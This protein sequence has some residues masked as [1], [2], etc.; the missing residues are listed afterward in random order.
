MSKPLGLVSL[1]LVTSALAAPHVAFAQVAPAKPDP[2]AT[3][4]PEAAADQTTPPADDAP[5]EEVPEVSVPGGDEIIVTGRVDR[6]IV[7]AAPQVVS[8]L[9]SADIAR[10]G[11]GDIAGALSR[12]TGLSVVGNGFVYVRGLGDRYSLALLNGSPLSSPE[13]LKRSIPLDLFPTSVIASS[14]VQKSYSANFPGEFG[15]GVINLT[16]KAIPK[17]SFLSFGGSISG[18]SETTGQLGYTY[19]GAPSDGTGFDDGSRNQP[20]ALAAFFASRNRISL[21]NVDT[22]AIGRQLISARNVVIQRNKNLPPNGSASISGG[23][24]WDIGDN[25]LG[26]IATLGYS[27]KWRTRDTTQQTASTV[28]LSQREL[29]FQRVITDNRVVVNGLL[30]L[31]FEFGENKLRWTNLYIRD[32][33]KQARLGVGTRESTSPTAT[34]QQQ[35]T[36]FF[37]RQLID[38]HIVAELKPIRGVSV[39]IR[40]GYAN[41]QREAPNEFSFEYFRSNNAADPFGAFFIN[42]LNGNQGRAAVS[43]SD[44]NEDLWSAGVDLSYKLTPGITATIG[45]AFT[46]TKR[47]TER[48]DFQFRAGSGLPTGVALLRPDLLLQPA[49]FDPRTGFGLTLIDTNEANPVFQANLRTNAGYGQVQAEISPTI[50]INAGVRYEKAQ[51]TVRPVQVFNIPF[52][53]LAGTAIRRDYFLPAATLTF[54]L[55]PQMQLRFNG[56]KTIARP[57]FRELIFQPYFD[58]DSNRQFRGNPNLTDSQLTNAE[59]RYEWY[60]AREQRVSVAAFYKRINRPIET[61]SSFSDNNV[62]SSFANAPL[63]NLYGAEVETQKYFNLDAIGKSPFWASRRAVVIANYT[64]TKSKISVKANDPVSVFAASST[65]ATDFFRDGEPLTGQ[66]DHLVNLQLGLEDTDKLSQQT[67]LITYASDRVTSRGAGLQPDIIEKPGFRLDFVARQGVKIFGIESEI[68]F[69]A[70]NLTRTKYQEVQTNGANR[71]FYNRYA[72]G[73]TVE[74]GLNIKF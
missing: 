2:Q 73:T 23:K 69:E 17:E 28:D 62:E 54:Q 51:Q 4:A 13:P 56:S 8:I 45:Y 52:A 14:L 7:K 22:A 39:D 6:N 31:G 61:F 49:N 46:D 16:T 25:K 20:P 9:S 30:G 37:E 1:L 68:N 10:T 59:A 42:R 63:A 36:L 5:V 12:V 58:P 3:T 38:S 53:S 26:L 60:F 35:D 19:F 21:G 70:R 64:Y 66:S 29:N 43:F 44:L 11:E 72:V 71:I 65:R 24:S 33:L 41:A 48:R 15:G 74:L 34:L 57:Q 27:N 50:S 32:T 47:R 55:A 67:I 40:A 18:D